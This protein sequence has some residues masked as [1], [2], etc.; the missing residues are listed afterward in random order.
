MKIMIE[1]Y[2]T[3]AKDDAHATIGRAMSDAID[4][5]DAIEVARSLSV[6]LSM[7]QRPDGMMIT[8][9]TGQK[10]YAGIV[11][12]AGRRKETAT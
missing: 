10:L 11:D 4:R 3:R 1:F 5:K 7:P 8:D 6:T 12:A 9:I 2:R